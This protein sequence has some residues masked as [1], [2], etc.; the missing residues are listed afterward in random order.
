MS[1]VSS[2]KVSDPAGARIQVPF[3]LSD[4][5]TCPGAL[6][7]ANHPTSRSPWATGRVS[8]TVSAGTLDPVE[9]A[10]PWTK[11]GV[12][13]PAGPA[14]AA[15]TSR[16]GPGDRIPVGMVRREAPPGTP[17]AFEARLALCVTRDTVLRGRRSWTG[18]AARQ[19]SG[20]DPCARTTGRD[21]AR[22]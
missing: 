8:G 6:Y 17:L 1:P 18:R 14:R 13:A 12:V 20:R 7:W 10:S 21:R 15:T 22:R 16:A 2:S 9:N 11:V 3:T 5:W 19:A 4:T